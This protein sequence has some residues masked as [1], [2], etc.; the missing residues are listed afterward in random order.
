MNFYQMNIPEITKIFQTNTENGLSNKQVRERLNDFGFNKLPEKKPPSATSIF[1]AQFTNPLMFILM[2]AAI[3]S[4]LLNE[5]GDAII[6]AIAGITNVI[7]GFIQEFK[8][9][10]SVFTLLSYETSSCLVKREGKIISINSEF[11]VPGDLVILQAGNKVPADIRLTKIAE[12]LVEESILTGE[13]KAVVKYTKPIEKKVTLGDQKNMVFSGTHIISGTAEGIVVATGLNTQLGKIA[14]TTHETTD[15]KTPLQKQINKLSWWLGAIMV[16][17]AISVSIIGIIKG[18]RFNEILIMGIALAVAAIPEGLLISVTAVL[19]LGMQKM[20]KRKALVRHLIAAETLGSV[21]V[22]CTDKTGTLTKGKMEVVEIAIK[23]EILKAPFEKHIEKIKHIIIDAI[24]NNNAHIPEKNDNNKN[25][26]IG[27]PTEIALLKL[28]NSLNIPINQTQK[29]YPRLFEKPFS[30][31]T[32]YMVT[33]NKYEKH[34]K[35][36]I[37]G[38]PEKI[39]DFCQ[40]EDLATFQKAEKEMTKKGLRTIAIAEKSISENKIDKNLHNLQ[41]SAIIGIKDP[42]RKEAKQTVKKLQEAGIKT[43]LVTGDHKETAINIANETGIHIQ[44]NGIITG[45]MLNNMSD[46]KLEENIR[47][48]DLF[49]RVEPTHKIRIVKAWKKLGKAIAM[50]GDG[51]NDAP[52]IKAADIGVALGSG[53]DIVH[54]VSDI[55]LLDNNL[56]T[57]EAAVKEGRTIFDNIRK[58]TVYLLSD[59]FS[60]IILVSLSILFGLPLPILASQLFWINLITDG[61]PNLALITEPAEVDIMKRKPRPLKE[62][63]LNKEAKALIFIIGIATDFMLFLFYYLLL[64]SNFDLK[65]IRSIMFTALAIDSL[66]YVYSIKTFHKPIYKTNAFSN[67]W[68]NGAIIISIG[69]QLGVIYIPLMQKLFKTVPLGISEWMIIFGLAIIKL[70]GIEITKDW[71]IFKESKQ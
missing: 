3:L 16:F 48:T 56:S 38:A 64:K 1:L 10:K 41:C 68:L 9:A 28:A 19:A 44:K 51:V 45:E 31:L 11:L 22:I 70:V 5:K 63:I 2:L 21:S 20:L 36:I 30:S 42:L 52:A 8:A 65:H 35:L 18:L 59:S 69:I 57:I 25:D 29:Q 14:H 23:N 61:L 50:I 40:Q 27:N 24:L 4:L 26:Y 60:E 34:N 49:V 47:F 33:I 6:I 62:Q 39:F 46:K 55:V 43:V 15:G 12:L 67:Q 7:V 17:L 32:K 71:F 37:K 54:E 53:S 58:I 13:S 66:F